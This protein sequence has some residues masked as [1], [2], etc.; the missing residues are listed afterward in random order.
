M[1]DT[2]EELRT[3]W[4]VPGVDQSALG[5]TGGEGRWRWGTGSHMGESPWS[6]QWLACRKAFQQEVRHGS[7]GEN[8]SHRSSMAGL[9][10]QRQSMVLELYSRK[11][12]RRRESRE[13]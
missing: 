13:R 8:L 5:P 2:A 12:G 10:E 7:L 3:K 1:L 9:D 4:E 11:A 6:G